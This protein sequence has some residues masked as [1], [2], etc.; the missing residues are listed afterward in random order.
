MG[1]NMQ[2]C[3]YEF[4]QEKG[5]SETEDLTRITGE[6]RGGRAAVWVLSSL[7][8]PCHF[9]SRK[10]NCGCTK[11]AAVAKVIKTKSKQIHEASPE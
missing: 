3:N 6:G 8:Q 2:L 1:S 4:S 7:L 10:A 11:P 9:H 5:E